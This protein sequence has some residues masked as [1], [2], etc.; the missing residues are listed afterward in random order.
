VPKTP[1]IRTR[2]DTTQSIVTLTDCRTGKR[3][4]YWLGEHGTPQSRER[5]HRVI[6]A[7][8][9]LGRRWPDP[10][11]V[12]CT[13]RSTRRGI[14]ASESAFTVTVLV[15]DYWRV[16]RDEHKSKRLSNI[17]VTLRLLRD[18]HGSESAAM[19]GPRKLSQLR[20]AMILGDAT[21][22]ADGR[23]TRKPWSRR[24]CN[25]RIGI[26]VSMFRW[27]ASQERVPATV[28]QA[29]GMLPPLKRG[30]SAAIEDKQVK[31]V[32]RSI[33]D[34]TLPHL[35]RQV[36]SMVELQLLTGARPGE[37]VSLRPCDIDSQTIEGVWVYRPHSHKNQYRGHDR[38]IHLGPRAQSI[39]AAYLDREPEAPL[40][41]PAEAEAERRTAASLARATPNSCGNTPGSNRKSSPRSTPGSRYTAD[42]YRRAI[43][44]AC[45]RAFPLPP[46]LAPKNSESQSA[47]SQRLSPE[48][49]DEVR[50]WRRQHRWHPH[51]LRHTAATEIR[52]QFGLEAAQLALGHSSAEVTDAVYAE[53][54]LSKVA[55]VMRQVG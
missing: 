38:A 48:Q 44:R 54:D 15:R 55:E 21:V 10:N 18:H 6:A 1:S 45:A 51:Q 28:P 34:A 9:S 47:W 43:E 29:L 11:D 53:R 36:R 14:E 39:I 13:V 52:R 4:D 16:V 19:F 27:A 23:T 31:S 49:H 3:R 50:R 30:R 46:A 7:W 25:D 32:E 37:I 8:E 2:P 22:R 35:S 42:S 17:K 40:F 24:T 12:G 20:E 26:I 5:Y 33:V 41:S